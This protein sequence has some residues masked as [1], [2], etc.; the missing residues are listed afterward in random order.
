[1]Y[2]GITINPDVPPEELKKITL[3]A[4]EA[5]YTHF[6]V[7]DQG[8][9]RDVYVSLTMLACAT[10]SIILGPGITHPYTRHAV[11][12]AISV[13]SL[14]EISGGRA[15]LGIGAGG[16]RTLVP[17]QIERKNPMK[18]CRET[19]EICRGLWQG[20]S[21]NYPGEFFKLASARPNFA[22]RKDI[23]VHW[24]ARGPKMLAMGGEIADVN[25]LHSI[26]DFE[27]A[28]VVESVLEGARRVERKPMMQL[29]VTHVFDE[30]S[31]KSAR[32]RSVYRLVDSSDEVKRKLGLN[33]ARIDEIRSLMTTR[34]L[35][36][37]AHLVSDEVLSHFI[38]E[39]SPEECAEKLSK[40]VEDHGLTGITFEVHSFQQAIE[41]IDR[42]ANILGMIERR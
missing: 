23:P 32:E 42:G 31:R 22:C 21:L 33:A 1:M 8:F 19:V 7:A 27:L 24:A 5:G 9:S 18:M 16:S 38:L 25:L 37:A 20:E 14:D 13:A 12:T 15:F 30:Q 6:Y 35:Q 39:G 2:K 4:E 28:N 10:R 40:T 34:G 3:H 36:A 41:I 17:L 26:P 11:V 29:A